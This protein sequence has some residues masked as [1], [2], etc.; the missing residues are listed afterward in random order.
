MADARDCL[1]SGGVAQD[2]SIV[3]RLFPEGLADSCIGEFRTDKVNM[4]LL[5]TEVDRQSGLVLAVTGNGDV[6]S[7]K[8]QTAVAQG[9]IPDILLFPQGA[10][11][12]HR[13]N[14]TPAV[15]F[16][17]QLVQQDGGASVQ[18]NVRYGI[19]GGDQG[20]CRFFGYGV[21]RIDKN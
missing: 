16:V 21:C 1:L 19:T 13:D 2:K 10:V 5:Q 12:A 20:I 8:F 6:L 18:Q 4:L 9:V 17:H 15:D 11:A 7:G 3:C 14:R